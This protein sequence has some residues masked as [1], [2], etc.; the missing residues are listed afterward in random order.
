MVDNV[1]NVK[2]TKSNG[3]ESRIEFKPMITDRVVLI[4]NSVKLDIR[5]AS[6]CSRFKCY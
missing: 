3:V 5:K 2:R 6:V 4:V 1:C